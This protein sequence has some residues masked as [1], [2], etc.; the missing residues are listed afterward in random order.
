M[1]LGAS[2]WQVLSLVFRQAMRPVTWGV[3]IGLAGSAAVYALMGTMVVAIENPDP[4]FGVN[5]WSPETL[6]GVIGFLVLVVW[7]ASWIP[8]R[9]AM[10]IEPSAAL[11]AE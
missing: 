3:V 11:R 2:R 10:R 4:L 6:A 1:A 7:L 9:R 8:A 5:P